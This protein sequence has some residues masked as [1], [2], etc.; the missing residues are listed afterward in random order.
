MALQPK[1]ELEKPAFKTQRCARCERLLDPYQFARTRSYFFPNKR[2]TICNSCVKEY[3]KE[4]NFDW[5]Y[6]DKLCQFIDIPFIPKEFE[7]LREMNGDDVFPIYAEVFQ[8]SEYES[9]GWNDYFKEFKRLEES[10]EIKKELPLLEE[11][12]RLELQK[13]WGFNYD[14]EALN[15]LENLYNGV[16]LTQN[17]NGALQDDQAIKLCKISYEVDSRIQEGSDFDKLLSSYDKLV[18]IAEF[19]PKNAKNANEFDSVGELIK[20]LE[21][22][23]FKNNFYDGVTRDIVDETIKNIQS[24]NQR[25]YTNETGIG[26]EISNRLNSLKI[27]SKMDSNYYDTQKEYDLDEFEKE[28]FEELLNDNEEFEANIGGTSNE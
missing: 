17:I 21:R 24:Y 4:R 8:S 2:I 10:D 15:Y 3:L 7:R 23:G 28:G 13:K 19:T 27:A 20:W 1:I 9:L 14:D 16:L 12:K 6:V 5:K 25:L 26:E 22:R 18:K 11:E